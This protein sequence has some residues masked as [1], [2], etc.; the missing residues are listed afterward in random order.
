MTSKISFI[1][2]MREDLKRRSWLAVFLAVIFFLAYPAAVMMSLDSMMNTDPAFSLFYTKAEIQEWVQKFLGFGDMIHLILIMATAVLIAVSEFS[3]LHSREKLD[4]Y[5]SLPIRRKKLFLSSYLTGALLFLTVFAASQILCLIIVLTKGI[6]NTEILYMVGKALLIRTAMFLFLYHIA[7]FAMLFTGNTVLSVLG[8][9]VLG[10]YGP[11]IVMLVEA[12]F[13]IG[14]YTAAGLNIDWYAYTTPLGILISM[15]RRLF[16]G[17]PFFTHA[18]LMLGGIVGIFAVNLW[19]CEHRQTEHAGMALAFP[20]IEQILKFLLVLPGA[21]TI[22]LAACAFTGTEKR[23]WIFAGFLFGVVVLSLLMEFIYHKDMKMI[24]RHKLGLGITAAVGLLLISCVLFDWFGYNTYLPKKEEI[25]AMS[26]SSGYGIQSGVYEEGQL[27][28]GSWFHGSPYQRMEESETE[29][30]DA[31]YK[32]ART[33]VSMGKWDSYDG[34]RC[35]VTVRF[36]LK[37]GKEVLRTYTVPCEELEQAE[38]VLYQS[39]WYRTMCFPLLGEPEEETAEKVESIEIVTYDGK[40]MQVLDG[41]EA[42]ELFLAY[43]KELEKMT[44]EEIREENEGNI[45]ITLKEKNG[46]YREVNG[47]PLT[48]KIA[49]TIKKVRE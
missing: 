25:Q 26:M 10:A 38:D 33:G 30:F 13:S 27:A 42:K 21:M 7:V 28:D 24:L 14:F 1:K 18:V 34:S 44:L 11:M 17:T 16:Y 3:Y 40:E 15:E 36:V 37:N 45:H 43:R 8:M 2:L 12:F 29:D 9:L 4:L 6:L 22:S 19:M 49:E 5:H 48:K 23:V 47:Y 41:D 39:E 32:L 31:I 46:V 20:K 35:D